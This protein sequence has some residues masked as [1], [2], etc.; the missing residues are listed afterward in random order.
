MLVN[1]DGES[2]DR[3]RRVFD[4]GFT[5]ARVRALLPLMR[6]RADELIDAFEPQNSDLG[7]DLVADYA[8]PF[9]RTIVDAAIGLPAEDAEQVQ[10][11]SNAYVLLINPLAPVRAHAQAAKEMGEYTRYLQTLIDERRQNRRDDLISDLIHGADGLPGMADDEVHGLVRGAA[12]LAGFDTT[13]DA[14]TAAVLAMLEH[15]QV[16]ARVTANPAREVTR[17]SQEVLRRDAPHR[18]LFRTVTRDTE[19]GGTALPEG[20]MLY[21]LFGS[22]NRDETVFEN[23]DQLELDRP[24]THK[25]LAF[26][27]GLHVCPGEPLARVEI[28][29]ALETLVKRVRGLR[30]APGYQPT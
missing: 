17:L 28:R 5:A 19:L 29:V 23:P 24:N 1:D 18:G 4:L 11:W 8:V 30:L 9:V 3:A 7:V 26:G 25:H 15:P 13:R 6:S 2:H 21:L 20:S 16:Q 27:K 14:I 10:A 12:R 22:G